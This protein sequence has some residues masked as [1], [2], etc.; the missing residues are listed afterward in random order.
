MERRSCFKDVAHWISGVDF[1]NGYS[2]L[3]I[4]VSFSLKFMLSGK[5]MLYALNI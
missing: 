4:I 2:G 1:D 3:F 5:H